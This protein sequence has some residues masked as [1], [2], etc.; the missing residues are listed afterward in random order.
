MHRSSVRILTA[1]LGCGAWALASGFACAETLSP[2][3]LKRV[4]LTAAGVAQLE[5]E[6]KVKDAATLTL[7]LRPDQIDDA[8]KSLIIDDPAGTGV[9]VQLDA[10]EPLSR[11]LADGPIPES[12]LSSPEA[13]FDALRGAVVQAGAVEGA[14]LAVTAETVAGPGETS[15]TKHRLTLS[16]AD[17]LKSLLIEDT[18]SLRFVDSALNDG[19]A[20]ALAAVAAARENGPRPVSLRLIGS[21]E[22]VVRASFLTAAP[23][24]KTAWRLDLA[25]AADKPARLQGW[26]V[27]ENVT[28]LD[29]TNVTVALSSGAPAAFRQEL[30][31]AR[32]VARPLAPPDVAAPLL[33]PVDV[34]A[35]QAAPKPEARALAAPAALAPA[36]AREMIGRSP[37]NATEGFDNLTFGLGAAVQEAET[38]SDGV[39]VRYVL[40]QPITLASG[41]SVSAPFLDRPAPAKATLLHQPRTDRLHPIAG[42]E[43]RNDGATALPPGPIAVYRAGAWIGDARV[44]WLPAGESR[45]ASFAVDRNIRVSSEE[46]REEKLAA[47]KIVKGVAETKDIVRRR[48]TWTIAGTTPDAT[49]VMVETPKRSGDE[50]VEA[51]AGVSVVAVGDV[52]RATLPLPTKGPVEISFTQ[53]ISRTLTLV[54]AQTDTYL[55]WVDASPTPALV[56]AFKRAKELFGW[57]EEA[58]AEIRKI[59]AERK[60]LVAEQERL[61]ANLQ[62]TQSAPDLQR[63]Y[64][65]AMGESEDRLAQL[66]KEMERRRAHADEAMKLLQEH[67]SGLSIP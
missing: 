23:A 49:S 13:L 64:Q 54:P 9:E 16:T 60:A 25:A 39:A 48:V 2:L 11:R 62:A 56:A 12:G 55:R 52:W 45:V 47:L 51:P 53:T 67:L 43:L 24:W 26:A 34:G 29:W 31:A 59:E 22:R 57:K 50:Q 46:R 7:R 37:H 21:G 44:G 6:A 20:R 15:T 10:A 28:A 58:Q 27:F 66:Q 42:V 63:R 5:L 3:T 36:P 14:I 19:L 8:L 35:P 17:G 41:R 18:P 38:K 40:P 30:W 33:P 32:P 61:R 65:K 4:T 1:T